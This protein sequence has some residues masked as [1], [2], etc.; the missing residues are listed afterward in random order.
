MRLDRPRL[1]SWVLT[2]GLGIINHLH[3]LEEY[4]RQGLAAA[5]GRRITNELLSKGIKPQADVSIN[6]A[7]SHALL[8]ACG[9]I[10]SCSLFV[11]LK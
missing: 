5:V 3:T 11:N 2:S 8:K 1:V 10:E 4:N 9:Y 6:N 7:P